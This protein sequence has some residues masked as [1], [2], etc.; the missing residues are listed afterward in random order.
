MNITS[1][2]KLKLLLKKNYQPEKLNKAQI[3]PLLTNKYN[4]KK[5]KLISTN[6]NSVN[7]RKVN[8]RK[9]YIRT[10]SAFLKRNYTNYLVKIAQQKSSENSSMVKLHQLNDLLYKL[11]KYDNELIIYNTHK[12]EGIKL[13]KDTLKQ[14]EVKLKKLI[15]LQDIDLPDEKISI[16]NFNEI[17]LSKEDIEKKLH[18]L[19]AEKVKI[20]YSVKNEEEYYRTIEYMLENEQKRLSIIKKES[21][22]IEEKIK[23]ISKYQKIV[24]DNN[25]VNDKKEE[26]FHKLNQAITNDIKLVQKVK[27]KQDFNSEKIQKEIAEKEFIVKELEEKIKQLQTYKNNDMKL[28]KNDIK[29]QIENAKEYEKKRINDEKKCIEIIFCLYIIQK[30]LYEEKNF[31]KNRITQSKEYQLLYQ[32]NN[33][34]ISFIKNDI[35]K[36]KKEKMYNIRYKGD[37]EL[38]HNENK[39]QFNSILSNTHKNKNMLSTTSMEETKYN[40]T[41]K[42]FFNNISM[43]KSYKS[44]RNLNYDSFKKIRG[45][46]QLTFFQSISDINTFY[47]EDVNNLNELISKFNSIKITKEEIFDYI[48]SLLSKLDFYGSQMNFIHNKEIILEQKRTNYEQKVKDIISK[49]FLFFEESTKNNE[50]CKQFYEKNKDFINQM[51]KD[52]KKLLMDTIIEKINHNDEISKNEEKINNKDENEIDEDNILFKYSKN[53]IMSIKNF[54]FTCSDLLKDIIISINNKNMLNSKKNNNNNLNKSDDNIDILLKDNNEEDKNNN[55]NKFIQAFKKISDF[56]KNKDIIIDDDYKLLLQYIKNL[57]KFCRENNEVLSK[58]DLDEI[59]NNLLE[60]FYKQGEMRQKMDKIFIKRF[61]AKKNTNLNNIF[62]YFISLSEQVNENVKTIYDLI[63]S[64][65]NEIYLEED[66]SEFKLKLNDEIFNKNIINQKKFSQASINNNESENI[67]GRT[68]RGKTIRRFTKVRSSRSVTVKKS[69]YLGI[70]KF[71]ELCADEEDNETVE[72][73]STKKVIIK[74]KKRFKTIDDKVIN[75]L[76]TPFLQKTVYLRQLNPNIP[77]IKQMTSTSSKAYHNIKKM[78]GEVDIISNQMKIYNN[79]HL[80]T[81]KLCDNTYNSLVKLI[82]ENTE[83]NNKKRTTMN[84]FRFKLGNK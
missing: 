70:N 45:K 47:S 31:D 18:N 66:N 73:Q 26:D 15:D 29:E 9:N 14:D 1:E 42:N 51:K 84:R 80:D 11:K 55:N 3:Y 33:E 74:K 13:L 34:E 56:L 61:L 43:N 48:S 32:L 68:S 71:E 30:Y 7:K 23:N 65:E 36:N 6:I 10:T 28:S 53:L 63:H 40:T 67:E 38:S 17:K 59:N 78:I 24:N 49:N 60:K 82:Y 19:M 72:T 57:I 25:K 12:L 35:K 41:A 52:N 4:D 77:G 16:K 22:E 8:T 46:T 2:S 58:E 37:E 75:K 5:S 44:S 83:K 54:F 69:N 62:I 21:Y 20:E 79:P 50:K 39:R 27:E 81:N 64:K 76:Y